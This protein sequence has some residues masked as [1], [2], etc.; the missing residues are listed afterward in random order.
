MP[1]DVASTEMPP[2]ELDRVTRILSTVESAD[3]ERFEPPADLWSRI[4]A[5]V[6]AEP[7]R[8]ADGAGT[9]VEYAIDAHD[10][11]I[12]TGGEWSAFAQDNGAPE[13]DSMAT[14]R[15]LWS[16][17]GS[18]EVRDLWR[19]LV[20]Q[21]RTT[22][23]AATVPLR[24]DA[25]GVR[26]W[27]EMTLTPQPN[28][29][30][31]F[32]STLSF[33]EHRPEVAFLAVRAERDGERPAVQVCSWCG[34]GHDGSTWRRI[35]DLVAELRLLEDALPSIDYGICPGCRDRMSSELHSSTATSPTAPHRG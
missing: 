29:V 2:P 31:Q 34:D 5:S 9:V 4:A 33:E 25:P 1:D 12:D 32:R 22:R 24:C 15:T 23:T 35:E 20:A 7:E 16:Y 14:D 3:L 6:A 21:V 18:D 28:G 11:V 13:L 10:R 17:F 8:V 19:L 30:V 27:F 26:R